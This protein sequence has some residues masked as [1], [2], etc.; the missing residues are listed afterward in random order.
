MSHRKEQIDALLRRH[1]AEILQRGVADPRVRGLISVTSVDTS[2]D[3]KHAK[4]GISVLPEG[5]ETKVIHGLNDGAVHL[6]H[7][8]RKAVALRVVPHLRFRI[9][10]GIKKEAGVLDAINE[11]M[12]RTGPEPDAPEPGGSD[13]VEPA[14]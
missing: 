10:K 12:R 3:L 14:N 9:D 11:A 2:P 8:L 4:V 6:Q 5:N 7:E 1:L 13:P